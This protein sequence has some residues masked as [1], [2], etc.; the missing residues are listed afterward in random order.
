VTIKEVEY[1]VENND[2]IN[3]NGDLVN[4]KELGFCTGWNGGEG[5]VYIDKLLALIQEHFPNIPRSSIVMT[6]RQESTIVVFSI[7]EL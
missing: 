7:K 2:R 1:D 5:V 6:I 4:T 3:F